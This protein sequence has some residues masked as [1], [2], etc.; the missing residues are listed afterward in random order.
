M[1]I[2]A[3]DL[4]TQ[5][6]WA[7]FSEGLYHTSGTLD[8]VVIEDFNVN[9]YPNKS[10]K[11]PQ[12]IINAIN[13]IITQIENKI[14]ELKGVDLII[15]EQ[16]TKGRNRHTQKFIEWMHLLIYLFITK[17]GLPI[18]YTDVSE[19][20]RITKLK[21]TKE[22]KEN[23]KKVSQGK[24]RGRINKKHLST[25]LVNQIFNLN[26]ILKDNNECDAILLGASYVNPEM[27]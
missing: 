8:K 10:D 26:K 16:S 21:L 15:I 1:K 14:L 9:N 3:L 17:R 25:R 27:F 6:G 19:W 20:R 5:T 2:L 22:D 24:K 11:Y 12:N 13:I 18:K 23:N 7:L 4:S